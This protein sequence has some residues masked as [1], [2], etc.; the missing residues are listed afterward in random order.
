MLWGAFIVAAFANDLTI[1]LSV[2]DVPELQHILA[3]YGRASNGQ[4]NVD[5][6]T[7]MDLAGSASTPQYILST[8]FAVHDHRLPVRVLGFDLHLS[9]DGVLEDWP[10]LIQQLQ[11]AASNLRHRSCA[12]Q[13][14]ALLV[15]SKVLSKLWYKG[16]LSSPSKRALGAITTLAWEVVW[17]GR[18]SLKPEAEIGR[19]P[20]RLGGVGFLDPS[21]QLTALQ[22]MWMAR[23]LTVKLRPPWW[24]AL[25]WVLSQHNSGR[26]T[27]VLG[28]HGSGSAT[29]LPAC[30]KPYF[31]AW[32]Q[33]HPQWSLD[34]DWTVREAL[35]F[36]IP[37]TH[38]A[39]AREGL[40]LLDF[41][42]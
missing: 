5:K 42:L 19:R 9:P 37:D 1:G 8:G 34:S 15:N 32:K 11:A 26:F 25:N 23:F 6:S 13:G 24:K 16:R 7:I 40:R 14:R 30:W 28:A 4:I 21:A 39:Q 10:A 2:T 38:S 17:A 41:T 35:C 29:K 31:D 3:E 27:L 12:L 36:P 22:A 33:L 20:P 18:T